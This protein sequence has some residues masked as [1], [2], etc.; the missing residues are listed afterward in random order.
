M[1]MRGLIV[2]GFLALLA[3]TVRAEVCKNGIDLPNCDVDAEK[4]DKCAPDYTV[5]SIPLQ[6]IWRAGGAATTAKAGAA[7]LSAIFLVDTTRLSL[8]AGADAGT[9]V[10]G[11]GAYGGGKMSL[12]MRHNFNKDECSKYWAGGGIETDG[13]YSTVPGMDSYLDAKLPVYI[14][15]FQQVSD[16]CILELYARGGVAVFD[17]RTAVVNPNWT[18]HWLRPFAGGKGVFRCREG[19]HVVVHGEDR[20]T[21]S[22][23]LTVDHLFNIDGPDADF[24]SLDFSKTWAV[25]TQRFGNM[26]I[27]LYGGGEFDY[28][29]AMD[30][31]DSRKIGILRGGVQLLH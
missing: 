13:R 31:N 12:S 1:K 25:N 6:K 10:T 27:G 16:K 7:D 19:I 29:R 8:E 5:Y 22:V 23:S 3:A 28:E 14:G 24:A 26:R 2:F 17:N 30:P 20:V 11:L 15:R 21:S 4:K 9:E 18:D